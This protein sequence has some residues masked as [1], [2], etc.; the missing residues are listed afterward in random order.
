MKILVVEDHPAQ[1]KL[2]QHVLS[3]AGHDVADAAA[4]EAAFTAIKL[5]R[6]H[7]ILLDLL[8]PD[9]DGMIL[10]RRLKADAETRDIPIVA[11]TSYPEVFAYLSPSPNCTIVF[12]RKRAEPRCSISTSGSIGKAG[13]WMA[14]F[15]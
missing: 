7:L 14:S 15:L 10:A 2:A 1:L 4:A 12:C 6:P 9:I 11:V 13:V 5:N 3:A 8:F